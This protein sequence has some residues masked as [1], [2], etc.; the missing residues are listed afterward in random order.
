MECFHGGLPRAGDLIN[1]RMMIRREPILKSIKQASRVVDTK[2]VKKL[3]SPS[4][5]KVLNAQ[6]LGATS[7]DLVGVYA[8]PHMISW[9]YIVVHRQWY[10]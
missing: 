4:N 8:Q 3:S 5:C 1:C 7:Y 9:E 2:F 6:G 10:G